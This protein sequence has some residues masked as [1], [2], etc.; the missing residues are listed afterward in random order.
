MIETP[1]QHG[2][3]IDALEQAAGPEQPALPTNAGTPL[4][5]LPERTPLE[6]PGAEPEASPDEAD[7]AAVTS[8]TEP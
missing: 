8:G 4:A 7:V 5:E 1:A 2:V 3:L 6:A